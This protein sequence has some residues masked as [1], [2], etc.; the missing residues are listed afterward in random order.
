MT[1]VRVEEKLDLTRVFLQFSK[2]AHNVMAT[3]KQ[4]AKRVLNAEVME[5]F[6]AMRMFLSKFQKEL[7]MEP[8]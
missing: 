5:K 1:I 3:E 4:L 7:M 6:R 8:V 2:R